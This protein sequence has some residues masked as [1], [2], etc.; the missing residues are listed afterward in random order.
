MVNRKK[1][2]H[3][4]IGCPYNFPYMYLNSSQL[5]LYLITDKLS[6]VC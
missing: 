5:Q 1:S 2:C 3:F 4:V 6:S